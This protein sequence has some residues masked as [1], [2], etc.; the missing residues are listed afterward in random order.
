M[1]N[2][3]T[4]DVIIPVYK[5]DH[6]LERLIEKLVAQSV[7]PRKII[8]LNTECAPEYSTIRIKERVQKLIAKIRISKATNL[9]IR[10]I[11]IAREDFDHGGTRHY[12]STLSNAEYIIYMTQDAI[13]KDMTLIENL[14]KPMEQPKVAIVYGKQEANKHA[15][16]LEQY[17]RLYNYPSVDRVKSKEDK[18]IDGIKTYF[19]SNVCACY[20]KKVYDELGG[21]VRRTIFNE[22]MIYAASAIEAGYSIVYSS[23]AKV[24]HSHSYTLMEQLRRNFDLGVSQ[25][26]YKHVF[27]NVSSEKEGLKFVRQTLSYLY[28]QKKYFEIFEFVMETGFK[29]I[30]YFLGKRYTSLPKSLCQWLSMNK[31][32]WTRIKS[33]K[34]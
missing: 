2:T 12:G 9:E 7:C 20:C 29:Y 31:A 13:P 27:S 6:K 24:I 1:M 8:L 10:I 19:C 18:Q 15:G 34:R 28:D 17:T 33:I 22:D 25:K 30:G 14:L 3:P 23:K 21:F 16:V 11:T 4:I 32:Y 26:E 5:P